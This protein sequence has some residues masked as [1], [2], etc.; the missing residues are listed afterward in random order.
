MEVEPS[1]DFHRHFAVDAAIDRGRFG[2]VKLAF[3]R[4]TGVRYAVKYDSTYST[5][6]PYGTVFGATYIVVLTQLPS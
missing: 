1:A 5:Y 2:I 4:T 6:V 3:C